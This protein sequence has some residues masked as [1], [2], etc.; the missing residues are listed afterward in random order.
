[1]SIMD[2]IESVSSQDKDS[3]NKAISKTVRRIIYCV[4]IFLLP[5]LLEFILTLLNDHAVNIC[6]NS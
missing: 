2:F 5:S 6:I 3:M 1:M 4:L